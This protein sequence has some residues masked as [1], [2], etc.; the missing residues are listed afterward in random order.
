MSTSLIITGSSSSQVA[1]PPPPSTSSS[2][3][4]MQQQSTNSSSSYLAELSSMIYVFT[5]SHPPSNLVYTVQDLLRSHLQHLLVRAK[6][7]SS[8]IHSLP[9]STTTTTTTTTSK[10]SPGGGGPSA[11]GGGSVITVEDMLFVI[12]NERG[13][14]ERLKGYLDW[15]DVRKR[16]KENGTSTGASG[17]GGMLDDEEGMVDNI[18][19]PDKNLK[20]G[21]A[22]TIHLPWE[23]GNPYQEYLSGSSSTSTS[24]STSR[25]G[26]EQG[27]AQVGDEEYEKALRENRQILKEA[28]ELTLNMS[29]EEYETYSQA[30][31][32]SFVYRK[33]K[34][35]RDFLLVDFAPSLS[36][37]VIDILG[38]LAYEHIRQLCRI[39]LIES[40]SRKKVFSIEEAR[41]RKKKRKL[42]T[43]EDGEAR[44]EGMDPRDPN[45][46][47]VLL[48][49]PPPS[50][51]VPL[52][53]VLGLFSRPV[54][55]ED[56][57]ISNDELLPSRG[58][59]DA[60][61]TSLMG[62]KGKARLKDG[63]TGGGGGGGGGI[64]VRDVLQGFWKDTNGISVGKGKGKRDGMGK[65]LRGFRGGAGAMKGLRSNF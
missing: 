64:E 11:I 41:R 29:K 2:S 55:K 54:E 8:S 37:E 44:L 63:K 61:D 3:K 5:L 4:P 6:L 34:K 40:I 26:G 17:G 24:T 16:T 65:G 9:L 18:E 33:G 48:R 47:S 52:G 56:H 59:E 43:L 49:P 50:T 1:P 30:R 25:S 28:D 10:N 19:E 57:P 58:E 23:F 60:Q 51:S 39:G 42:E 15:K 32:A 53:E 22:G 7:H 14:V 21:K 62:S 12:R 13:M 27:A 35:F 36:E 38:F 46:P 20:V 31:Q 45:Y